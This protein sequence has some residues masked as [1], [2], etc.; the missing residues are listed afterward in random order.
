MDCGCVPILRRT[1]S[2]QEDRELGFVTTFPDYIVV[3]GACTFLKWRF[4]HTCAHNVRHVE[5]GC[6]P[7]WNTERHLKRRPGHCKCYCCIWYG[8]LHRHQLIHQSLGVAEQ[9]C[10]LLMRSVYRVS[11]WSIYW[12]FLSLMAFIYSKGKYARKVVVATLTRKITIEDRWLI[13]ESSWITLLCTR[14][15]GAINLIETWH[16]LIQVHN[17][18][19]LCTY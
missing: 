4:Q 16:Q 3:L 1:L 11:I 9:S 8:C 5:C 17:L 6:P 2:L 18:S 7:A 15:V 12:F 10:H 19:G 14:F 13:S